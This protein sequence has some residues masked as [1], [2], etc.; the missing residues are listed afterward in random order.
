MLKDRVIIDENGFKLREGA[1]PER[2]AYYVTFTLADGEI[3]KSQGREI[4]YWD[5]MNP[6]S[7]RVQPNS[8]VY[9]WE[10]KDEIMVDECRIYLGNGKVLHASQTAGKVKISTFI[11]SSRYWDTGCNA[12]GYCVKH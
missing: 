2:K 6:Y 1:D 10:T 11:S 7:Q 4:K 12:A 5:A 8:Y 3:D 9:I